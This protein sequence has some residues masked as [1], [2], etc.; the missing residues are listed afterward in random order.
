[1]PRMMQRAR[2]PHQIM[3]VLPNSKKDMS[4]SFSIDGK[5]TRSLA[6]QQSNKSSSAHLQRM[7]VGQLW[8]ESTPD[9]AYKLQKHLRQNCTMNRMVIFISRLLHSP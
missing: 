1:M 6:L 8:P 3:S 9:Q 7:K 4:S 2:R 5:L